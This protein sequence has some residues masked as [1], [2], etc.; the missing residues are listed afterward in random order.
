MYVC[1]CLVLG[2]GYLGYCISMGSSS[3]YVHFCVEALV[4][5]EIL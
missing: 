2:L 5:S 4:L 3:K 1:H